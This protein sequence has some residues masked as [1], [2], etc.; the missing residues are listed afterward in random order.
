MEGSELWT[1]YRNLENKIL[2]ILITQQ[3]MD[4]DDQDADD[5][6]APKEIAQQVHKIKHLYIRQIKMPLIDTCETYNKF[7]EWQHQLTGGAPDKSFEKDYRTTKLYVKTIQE[8]ELLIASEHNSEEEVLSL[9]IEYIEERMKDK[10]ENPTYVQNL[11]ERAFNR[12]YNNEELWEKYIIFTMKKQLT[13]T[14]FNICE[15]AMK[16]FPTKGKFLS[17]CIQ[18]VK[19]GTLLDTQERV[20]S[21]WK[22]TLRQKLT[23]EDLLGVIFARLQYYASDTHTDK[24]VITIRKYLEENELQLKDQTDILV[25]FYFYWIDLECFVFPKILKENN[26]KSVKQVYDKLLKFSNKKSNIWLRYIHTMR[27]LNDINTARSLF[28]RGLLHI[29]FREGFTEFIQEW[30]H[31]ERCHGDMK[32][33]GEAHNKIETQHKILKKDEDEKRKAQSKKSKNEK[34]RKMR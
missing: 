5:K 30:K 11:F 32:S 17:Y 15:R 23:G 28:K 13:Q 16:K 24:D 27:T 33:M 20:E 34:E 12:F 22:Q 6:E 3:N 8:R 9:W 25:E 1:L 4:N 29:A 18:T 19:T 2:S 14:L 10:K 7:N 31:F 26:V 21:I